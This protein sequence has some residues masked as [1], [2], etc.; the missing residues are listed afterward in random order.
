VGSRAQVRRKGESAVLQM[1]RNG[2]SA[3]LQVQCRD[4]VVSR[5]RQKRGC[6][7]AGAAQGERSFAG[8]AYR[9]AKSLAARARGRE[10]AGEGESVA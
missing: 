6:S 9:Q 1:R 4:S 2:E 7:F 10:K 8:A 5:V 3:V